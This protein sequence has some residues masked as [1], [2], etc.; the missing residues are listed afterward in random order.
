M[1]FVLMFMTCYG[2][3]RGHRQTSA[4]ASLSQQLFMLRIFVHAARV[5]MAK[6]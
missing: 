6:D 1:L 5:V 4:D 3:F 2:A